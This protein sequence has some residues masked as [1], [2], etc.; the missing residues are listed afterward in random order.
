MVFPGLHLDRRR[1]STHWRVGVQLLDGVGV[2][3][4][5]GKEVPST[6]EGELLK[7]VGE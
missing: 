4:Y 3:L 1:L 5:D 7:Q 6:N 2:G